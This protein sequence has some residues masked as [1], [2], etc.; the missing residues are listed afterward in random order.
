MAKNKGQDGT[1]IDFIAGADLVG[2]AP[3]AIGDMVVVSH[4]DV[5]NGEQGLGHV[6]GVWALPKASAGAISQGESV[7]LA[8]GTVSTTNTGTYAGKAWSS[9]GAG[10]TE[11]MVGLNVGH[12]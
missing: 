10:E 7:Y 8:N 3:V 12:A 9:A 11:V 5:A 2:G 1:T 4:D 6:V